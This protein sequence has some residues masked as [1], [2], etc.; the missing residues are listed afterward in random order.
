MNVKYSDE[1]LKEAVGEC[2]NTTEV[3]RYI[4][5]PQSSG[6]T[7]NHIRKRIEK[8]GIDTSHFRKG[9]GWAKGT[10][11]IWR[12]SAKDILTLKKEGSRRTDSYLLRRSLIEIGVK[13]KCAICN[14]LNWRGNEL[15]LQVDHVD[16]NRHNDRR[17]NLRFLCP[18]CHSQTI[19]Y[20]KTKRR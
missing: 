4:G 8:L 16:G 18:N 20:G 17:G 10:R 14:L 13:Y 12:K 5:A 19:T 2:T 1:L 11:S 9:K 7:H 15:V 3:L 6:S